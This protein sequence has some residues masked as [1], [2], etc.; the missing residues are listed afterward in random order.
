[1]REKGVIGVAPRLVRCD[2]RFR[3]LVDTLLGRTIIVETVALG[4]EVLR[5]G[6]GAVVTM[7]GVLLRPNGSLSGGIA[8]AAAE[9][10]SRQRELDEL[11]E[12]IEAARSRFSD[13][14]SRLL[15]EREALDGAMS[16]FARLDPRL[17]TLRDD[18]ARRQN[19]LLENR[20]RLIILRSE[21]VSLWADLRRGDEQLDWRGRRNRL[22]RDRDEAEA[23]AAE[24]GKNLERDREALNLVSTRRNAAIDGVSE[25]AAAHADL[26]GEAKSLARQVELIQ[27]NLG[28]TEGR[29][30]DRET[31]L[32]Q[33]EAELTSL[34]QRGNTSTVELAT[35]NE[36]L[37]SLT[38]EMDPAEGEL[39]HLVSRERAM[40]DQA[41]AARARFLDAERGY[42]EA[43]SNVKLRSDEIEAL[44]EL[45]TN[46]GF[47]AEG[48]RVVP[49]SAAPGP[50]RRDGP[51]I[52]GGA[53]VDIDSLRVRI[54][55]LRQQIRGLGPVNEQA[56]ADYGESKER[57]DF[58]K[59]QVDD[60]QGSEQTLL[61]AIDELESNIRERLKA[62]FAVVDREFQRYF[63]AFFNGGSAH[64]SLT[65]PDDYANSG[66]DIVAQPPGKR[67]S[68]LAMLSGG[69]RALTSLALLLS[70]LE[71]H[72]SPICVLDEVD[73]ALDETNVGRF[74]EALRALEKKTQFVIITHN[75]R[76]IEAADDIY[77]V[78]MGADNTSRVLSLRLENG[79]NPSN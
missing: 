9:S 75:P 52:R 34:A 27:A 50:S 2:N 41:S 78:S 58:L 18:R 1:M 30:K 14:E 57:F 7:D 49:A 36:E 54:A 71:A 20:G 35:A 22:I 32:R 37:T 70:L 64:L 60:L 59:G 73:A 55:E 21:A 19:A 53:D 38:A 39:S 79:H 3:P 12:A 44:R 42:L 77:G 17:Q 65:Q 16:S 51:Q 40:R 4:R 26:E 10:F 31:S 61:T 46:E 15:R 8:R 23:E 5:R 76:T 13:V 66:I 28:R 45:I 48:D 56:Q 43:E 68:T 25:A 6:L 74:V 47:R 24:A 11:P 67:V 72:P 62:T 69:E 63:E 29:L 33:I